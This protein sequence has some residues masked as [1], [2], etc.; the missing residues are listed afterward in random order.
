MFRWLDG[1]ERGARR[2]ELRERKKRGNS[3]EES[4]IASGSTDQLSHQLPVWC[5]LPKNRVWTSGVQV[6]TNPFVSQHS[7][8]QHSTARTV[9]I[10]THSIRSHRISFGRR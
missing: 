4:V 6:G 10:V 1:I 2:K 7:T 9:T 8:A 5:D 3:E